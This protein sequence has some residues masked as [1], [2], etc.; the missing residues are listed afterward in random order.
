MIRIPDDDSDLPDSKPSARRARDRFGF[1]P[2]RSHSRFQSRGVFRQIFRLGALLILVFVLMKKASNP[3]HYEPFFGQKPSTQNDQSG[4]STSNQEQ[5]ERNASVENDRP[6]EPQTV[7]SKQPNSAMPLV[8]RIPSSRRGIWIAKLADS[9]EL[10]RSTGARPSLPPDESGSGLRFRL[11][12]DEIESVLRGT[13]LVSTPDLAS[14]PERIPDLLMALRVDAM[15]RVVDGSV[16]R[17]GDA[18][19]LFD[20]LLRSSN[21]SSSLEA[22]FEIA[23]VPLLQ[24][25]DVYRGQ[26]IRV[27]GEILRVERVSVN[28]NPFLIDEYWKLWIHPSLDS[29][30]P[31]VLVARKVPSE[32]AALAGSLGKESKNLSSGPSIDAQGLYLKRLAYRSGA[33]AD[34]APLLVG[35]LDEMNVEKT[36]A[37]SSLQKTDLPIPL[38]LLLGLTSVIGIVIAVLVM[39]EGSTNEKRIRKLRSQ[40][41]IDTAHLSSIVLETQSL[42]VDEN[43]PWKDLKL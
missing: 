13:D 22:A 35:T 37:K 27:R 10:A 41:P 4:S 32:I 40:M 15:N 1:T 34:V 14:I 20:L 39:K 30:R 18:D 19:A 31:I 9:V 36:K 38:G 24:Q 16:F 33:G 25:P 26:M 2:T 23:T 17:N 12:E 42:E 28:P 8:D 43:S 7:A 29:V 11:S 5:I 3:K 6:L 21:V